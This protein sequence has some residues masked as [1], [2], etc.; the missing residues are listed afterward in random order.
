MCFLNWFCLSARIFVLLAAVALGEYANATIRPLRGAS[1]AKRAVRLAYRLCLYLALG[2]F[3]VVK[4]PLARWAGPMGYPD[5]VVYAL[6]LF[7]AIRG[8]VAI[9]VARRAKSQDKEAE[10]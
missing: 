4:I 9:R 6:A 2:V 10:E 3:L 7:G 8:I 5:I 1:W